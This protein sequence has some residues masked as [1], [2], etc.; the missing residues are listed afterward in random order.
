M[1]EGHNTIRAV[2]RLRV[3]ATYG[4]K[5]HFNAAD[6]KERYNTRIGLSLIA[7]NVVIA[8]N[9]IYVL[10]SDIHTIY[11]AISLIG[12]TATLLAIVQA[13]FNYSRTAEQH[14]MVATKYLHIVKECSRTKAYYQDGALS[15]DE[16]RE[17]LDNLARKYELITEDATCLSTN[18]KDYE[19]AREGFE[20]GE[21][22]YSQGEYQEE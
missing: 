9:L 11:T 5:K 17:R 12:F 7:A 3:D 6:R 2:E 21:E 18:R 4:K 13:F 14:R 8:S 16:L 20:D 22:R 15:A 10:V 1:D 19:K